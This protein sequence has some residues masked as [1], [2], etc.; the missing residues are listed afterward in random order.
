MLK[1]LPMIP[2]IALNVTVALHPS[3]VITLLGV[4]SN[5]F[6]FEVVLIHTKPFVSED[7]SAN[8]EDDICGSS[9]RDWDEDPRSEV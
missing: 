7:T 6:G 2:V 1:T 3:Y 9:R 8:V 4:L 5:A